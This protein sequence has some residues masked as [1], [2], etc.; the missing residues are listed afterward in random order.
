MRRE[1]PDG[2]LLPSAFTDLVLAY[3]KQHFQ[4]LSEV[5][6]AAQHASTLAKFDW[7]GIKS[8]DTCLAC[9]TRVPQHNAS[10]SHILCENCL[11]IH[12]NSEEVD[13][14]LISRESCMLCQELVDMKIR[15]RPP[16]A[17]QSILC[18][19]GGGIRGIIPLMI[20]VGL[21]EELDLPIPIQEFFTLS[22]GTSVGMT[23]LKC[24]TLPTF[25]SYNR[26]METL[27]NIF[28]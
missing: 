12:G 20:L 24:H 4:R 23:S 1:R 8:S 3:L 17:G 7:R 5:S 15:I 26:I 13:P 10:C 2:I 21:Q 25:Y 6:S 18:I 16:T 11:I 14:W 19:D 9:L 22:Y 27:A 28:I